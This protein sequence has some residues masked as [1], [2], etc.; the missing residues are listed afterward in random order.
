MPDQPTVRTVLDRALE[1]YG[2]LAE[3]GEVI[4]DEWGY[5]DDLRTTWSARLEDL[6]TERGAE[7]VSPPV[8]AAIDAAVEEI[9]LI[10]DP[11]RAI[12]WLS[13][14]PQVVC[15]ALGARP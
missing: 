14:F 7:P 2:A 12:D 10:T 13:T 5:I 15:V 9:G 4:D 1:A 3:V 6:A 11:H 8:A